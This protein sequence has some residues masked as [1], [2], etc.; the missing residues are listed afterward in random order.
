VTWKNFAS[1]L[2][3][4]WFGSTTHLFTVTTN[5]AL[6]ALFLN[7]TL[8]D[9]LDEAPDESAAEPKDR[10]TVSSELGTCNWCSER[11]WNEVLT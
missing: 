9:N 3:C 6:V 11:L 8:A 7:E 2:S 4:C 10:S 1:I 5:D